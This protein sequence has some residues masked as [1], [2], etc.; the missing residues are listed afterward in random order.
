MPIAS[1]MTAVRTDH[2]VL[3]SNS[4]CIDRDTVRRYRVTGQIAS[5]DPLSL[6][7]GQRDKYYNNCGMKPLS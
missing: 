1:A 7:D 3:A 5:V 6:H 4:P 2:Q